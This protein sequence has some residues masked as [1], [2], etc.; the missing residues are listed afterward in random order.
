MPTNM[1]TNTPTPAPDAAHHARLDK[2]LAILERLTILAVTLGPAIA[3]PLVSP[4][5]ATIIN[6]E[7]PIAQALAA[8]LAT[9][10]A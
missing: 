6:A 2:F 10:A 9:P 8:T 7:A 3:A 1:P 4:K 5:A